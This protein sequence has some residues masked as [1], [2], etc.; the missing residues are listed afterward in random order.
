MVNIMESYL[1]F[2]AYVIG[3]VSL[4]VSIYALWKLEEFK[5]KLKRT[6]IIERQLNDIIRKQQQPFTKSYWKK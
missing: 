5:E 1:A 6:S 4:L 2:V 3:C